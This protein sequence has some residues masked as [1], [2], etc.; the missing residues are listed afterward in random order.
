MTSCP[1]PQ[2]WAPSLTL[3]H[4]PGKQWVLHRCLWAESLAEAEP[5]G[6]KHPGRAEVVPCPCGT[7]CVRESRLQ[8]QGAE[9]HPPLPSG[10]FWKSQPELRIE[11]T[12]GRPEREAEGVSSSH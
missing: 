8:L 3:M 5:L 9:M 6:A 12:A 2:G 4:R 1:A 10:K 11:L 7:S